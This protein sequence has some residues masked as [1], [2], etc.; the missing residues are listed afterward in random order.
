[1][2]VVITIFLW[3]VGMW[4]WVCQ[5]I[6]ITTGRSEWHQYVIIV[7]ELDLLTESTILVWLCRCYSAEWVLGALELGLI[8]ILC[9]LLLLGVRISCALLCIGRLCVG[10][11]FRAVKGLFRARQDI[12]TGNT[13]RIEDLGNHA[14]ALSD[15]RVQSRQIAGPA[16][17]TALEWEALESTSDTP[18][19]QLT[20]EGEDTSPVS[21]ASPTTILRRSSRP[22]RRRNRSCSWQS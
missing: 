8:L 2:S 10:K 3:M 9:V 19:R 11:L 20:I 6:G 22:V 15:G 21:A 5:Q 4:N 12:A 1:M 7:S 16:V 18:I 13:G 17:A 14:V